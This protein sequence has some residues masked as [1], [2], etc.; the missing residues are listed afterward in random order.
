MEGNRQRR[1][2][3]RNGEEGTVRDREGEDEETPE[4]DTARDWLHNAQM[5]EYKFTVCGHVLSS[6]AEK[7]N[8]GAHGTAP[9]KLD[10]T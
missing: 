1:K 3:R 2:V 7:K 4:D 6:Q 10:V 8:A 9:E 5:S